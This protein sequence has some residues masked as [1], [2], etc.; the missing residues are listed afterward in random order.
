MRYQWSRLALLPALLLIGCGGDPTATP[1]PEPEAQL[2]P[3][4]VGEGFQLKTGTFAVAAGVEKQDCYFFRVKDLAAAGGLDPNGPVYVN[5]VQINQADGSHHMN[6]FRVRT[7]LGL[8]PN[9]GLIQQGENG[10]GECF[11]SPNW[12]DWPLVAN[13]QIDGKL[14]WQFPEGVANE[15]QP[16]EWLMLQTHYVNATTQDT[17]SGEGNVRVNF[18][19]MPKEEVKDQLGTLF[20]TKQSIRVCKSNPAPS[21]DGTCQFGADS[22]VNI[23]GANAHFHSRGKQFDIF[24]WDG[25]SIEPPADGAR[26]YRS[27]EWEEPPM[28]TSPQ[29]NTVVP[30]GGGVWYTCGFQ[31]QMPTEK[32]GCEGLDALDKQQAGDCCY[33]FGGVVDANEHCNIFVYYYPKS[34][35]I[36]CY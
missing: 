15:F 16:D 7:I 34:D 9:K 29:L 1:V 30:P 25:T 31:W 6:V 17:P 13:S 8:D 26:F 33:T 2:D 28:L 22:P 10:K 32:L 27:T 4:P 21:F 14:D 19:T 5:R 24:S 3:P 36:L 18:W 12:A 23:I 11:K 20:A 35:N